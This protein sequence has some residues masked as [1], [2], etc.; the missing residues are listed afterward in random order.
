MAIFEGDEWCTVVKDTVISNQTW[1]QCL[2][3]RDILEILHAMFCLQHSN[4]MGTR[5]HWPYG[6]S[7][8]ECAHACTHTH[9]HTHT[10]SHTHILTVVLTLTDKIIK[11]ISYSKSIGTYLEFCDYS[12]H[13]YVAGFLF[14]TAWQSYMTHNTWLWGNPDQW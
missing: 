5:S 12:K 4:Y 2:S 6:M 3:R 8:C 13:V 7:T 11:A 14:G 10:P 9:T 1:L